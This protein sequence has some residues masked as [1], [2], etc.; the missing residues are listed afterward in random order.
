MV[1]VW[2]NKYSFRTKEVRDVLDEDL[3]KELLERKYEFIPNS[4]YCRF[5]YMID[6]HKVG[7]LTD[8]QLVDKI[9]DLFGLIKV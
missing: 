5:R 3:E 8:E 1:N 9:Y 7:R 4:E 2:G 6:L